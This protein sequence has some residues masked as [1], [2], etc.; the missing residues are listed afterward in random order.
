MSTFKPFAKVIHDRLVELSKHELYTTSITGDELWAA[1]LAAFPE[2]TNPIY[3]TR[4]EHDC[5]CCKNFVRNFGPLVAI[6][7]G[8]THSIWR[9]EG[10]EHP[11]N[12]VASQLDSLVGS[13]TIKGVF[14][15]SESQYGA[16]TT[17]SLEDGNTKTWNHFHGRVAERHQNH[18]PDKAR[19]DINT[20]AQ[21]FLRGLEELTRDAI[22]QVV[23]LI[24]GNALYRGEEHLAAVKAFQKLH[25]QYWLVDS[26]GQDLFIW[27]H[28][29]NPAVRFRNT[30]IGTLVDDLSKGVDLEAAVRSFEAKVAPANYKRTSALITPRMVADA[31]KT[32]ND[33]GLESALERRHATLSDVSVNNVL[34]VDND[35]K[36]KMK[37]GVESLLLAA[38]V[39]PEPKGKPEDISIDDFMAKVIPTA[40]SMSVMVKNSQQANFMSLTAPVH[41]DVAPLFKWDNNFAWSYDGNVTDSIKERVKRAGGNITTAKLRV[42]L[43]WFNYD[44]LDIHVIE[45]SGNHID[46]RNKCGKLDVDMNAGGGQTREPVENVSW[47]SANLRDGVYM[48]II[49]QW[50]R[51]ETKDVGFEL[52]VESNG[53]IH[54]FAYKKALMDECDALVLTVKNGAVV[55][56]KLHAD[57]TGGGF[58]QEKWGI[59]TEA[60]TKVNTLMYSPNYWDDN[61]TGNRHV[62]FILDGCVSDAAT[63]G[64]Y[65]E[66]LKPELEKH[67]K[68]FEVL[69]NRTQ[70]TPST[71]Q[72][73]GVGFSST[74]KDTVVV[75]VTTAKS[76][77]VYNVNF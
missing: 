43:A 54:R 66:F 26:K 44:D 53:Q 41:A 9:A 32:I 69:G 5:S 12:V 10:L 34:W 60:W 65:N 21:V 15:T 30:V 39:A 13:A 24:E 31:M 48:V 27:Q 18:M 28:A 22:G 56:I 35:A 40:V 55:D 64:I 3:K 63:R 67:R 72:L 46:F 68:V 74:N 52:E 16:E 2:G 29:T 75:R 11:F 33:L 51:R 49:D 38:A 70:C 59:K 14:R 57:L 1:Y 37:G 71:E 50:S 76:N 20:T 73:S 25:N 61:H 23:Q 8:Q 6:I 62:F 7:N 4:T 45:P 36:A 47:T 19:G 17:R 58:S 42:S 77:R